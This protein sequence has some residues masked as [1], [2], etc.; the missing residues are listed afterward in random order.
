MTKRPSESDFSR[1]LDEETL[2]DSQQFVYACFSRAETGKL[3]DPFVR[4]CETFHFSHVTSVEAVIS[5]ISVIYSKEPMD[6]FRGENGSG[7]S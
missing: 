5:F 6:F 4:G 3:P 1:F 7:R 2:N